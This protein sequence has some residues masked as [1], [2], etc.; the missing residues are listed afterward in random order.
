MDIK[1]VLVDV[2][3]TLLNDQ[4]KITPRTIEAISRLKDYGIRFGIASGRSPYI[5]RRLLKGWGIDQYTD[6]IMGF[7][8]GCTLYFDTE[9]YVHVLPLDGEVLKQII[10]D[11]KDYDCTIGVYEGCVYHAQ[12]DDRLSRLTAEL[13]Q[14]DLEISDLSAFFTKKH[15]KVLITAEEDVMPNVVKHYNDIKPTTYQASLSSPVR[16]ECVNP[17]L[18]KSK[19]IEFICERLGLTRDQVLTFGDM[20]NDYD[21]IRDYVGVAMG[22]GH[23]E[24]KKVAKYETSS[25]NEDGIAVFLE[26]YIF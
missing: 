12:H 9:D 14:I 1:L 2:D 25:N 17:E 11:Y 10:N 4:L 6:L 26:K 16:F 20:M 22:N 19:G 3:G 18:S 7:N 24:V 8:G 23:P 21:M 15:N 13:N 5:T